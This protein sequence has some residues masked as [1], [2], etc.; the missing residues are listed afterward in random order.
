MARTSGA[1]GLV[2]LG[3]LLGGGCSDK[4]DDD[5]PLP[6]T[7]MDAGA[8]NLDATV[9]TGDARVDAQVDASQMDAAR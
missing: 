5:V 2:A 6:N 8:D 3:L 7:L 9:G 1:W 4:N